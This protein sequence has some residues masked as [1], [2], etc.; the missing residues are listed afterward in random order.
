MALQKLETISIVTH[1]KFLGRGFQST[2]LLVSIPNEDLLS[3]LE[4]KSKVYTAKLRHFDYHY[5]HKT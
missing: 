3:A 5:K 4:T 1:L 2:W